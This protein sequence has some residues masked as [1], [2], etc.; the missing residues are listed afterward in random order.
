M[1]YQVGDKVVMVRSGGEFFEKG[2]LAIITEVNHG[3]SI[4]GDFTINDSYFQDGQW[5]FN[6]S[7][8]EL[9]DSTP[10]QKLYIFPK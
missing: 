1:D 9:Y 3:G 2:D 6:Q 8:I 5:I 7:W 10:E 4:A